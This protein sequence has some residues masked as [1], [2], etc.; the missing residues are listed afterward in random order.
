MARWFAWLTVALLCASCAP[1]PSEDQLVPAYLQAKEL[2]VRGEL[3]LALQSFAD[4]HTRAPHFHSAAFM[5]GKCYFLLGQGVEAEGIWTALLKE[6]PHH[7]DA[8]KWLARLYLQRGDPRRAAATLGDAL[9]LSAEDPE[10]L[11][12]LGRSYRASGRQDLAIQTLEK[13]KAL[14]VRLAEASLELAEIYREAGLADRAAGELAA[15][16]ALLGPGSSLR[17]PLQRVLQSIEEEARR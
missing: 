17:E 10:L 8:R 12:L 16:M 11:L 4:I 7:V 1:T 3:A 14:G 13:A 9:R 2:Y 15:A 6:E 5:L